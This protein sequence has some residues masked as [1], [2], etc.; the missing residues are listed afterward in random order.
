[1][2]N[3][4]GKRSSK[5]VMYVTVVHY[6]LGIS[7]MKIYATSYS[8]TL[9]KETNFYCN[10]LKLRDSAERIVSSLLMKISLTYTMNRNQSR[11]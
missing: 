10:M 11:A 7:V 4:E 9:G 1:M 8:F 2:E 6:S 3:Q 5:D